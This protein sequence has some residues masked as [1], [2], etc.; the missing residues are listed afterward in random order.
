MDIGISCR[1][2][3]SGSC[4]VLN[5]KQQKRFRNIL[6]F[7]LVLLCAAFAVPR[8]S[9]AEDNLMDLFTTTAFT[10]SWE[11]FSKFNF[12]GK[13]S[14]FLIS[15]FC[16]FGLT[17][18]VLRIVI[19]ILYK[20]AESLFDR[21]Y[22]LKQCG[23]GQNFFGIPA[24]GRAVFT[25]NYGTGADAIIG[26][27]LAMCPNLKAYSDYNPEKM[28]YNLA[29][30]DT[31]TTYILKISCPTIMTLFFF[32]IGFDGTLWQA[33]GNVVNGISQVAKKAVE[34]NLAG[35]V[36]KALN[37]GAYYQFNFNTNDEL[38]KFQKNI[39]TSVYNKLLLKMSSYDTTTMQT[40]G[41]EIETW[42]VNHFSASKLDKLNTAKGARK[43][44]EDPSAAKNLSFQS[45]INSSPELGVDSSRCYAVVTNIELFKVSGTSTTQYV[46][47]YVNKKENADETDYYKAKKGTKATNAPSNSDISID[48]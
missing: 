32:T 35:F 4:M 27:I 22:E 37:A 26:F 48:K 46:H 23:K 3:D 34:V 15:A 13:I 42:V 11:V 45:C 1:A 18:T 10:G 33:Y 41:G 28:A 47:V 21:I 14:N 24:M 43:V 17:L 40:V 44:S 30:D 19:T 31:V 36:N 39:A 7:Y 6:L 12:I 16:L 38:G 5:E 29:E 2:V 8:F 9:L 20:S 25:G